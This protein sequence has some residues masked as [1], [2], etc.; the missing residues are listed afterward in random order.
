LITL[1][2]IVKVSKSRRLRYVEHVAWMREK[3]IT[4]ELWHVNHLE[5]GERDRMVKKVAEVRV[6]WW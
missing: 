1:P 6:H 3:D 5:D 2:N 4:T